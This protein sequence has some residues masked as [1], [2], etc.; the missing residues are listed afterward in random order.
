MNVL[1]NRERRIFKEYLGL[2][3]QAVD[4]DGHKLRESEKKQNLNMREYGCM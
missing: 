2:T 1:K 4:K 3:S